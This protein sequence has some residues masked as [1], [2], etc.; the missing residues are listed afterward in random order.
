MPRAGM[1]TRC[2]GPDCASPTHRD[3]L[4][5]AIVGTG[6]IS[7]DEMPG[8]CAGSD[9]CD[10]ADGT[11]ASGAHH[12][13]ATDL[14]LS[15]PTCL[16]CARSGASGETKPTRPLTRKSPPTPLPVM[17]SDAKH[18][19]LPFRPPPLHLQTHGLRFG[20]ALARITESNRACPGDRPR[21][22]HSPKP[23]ARADTLA[24]LRPA[25]LAQMARSQPFR[26]I[27]EFPDEPQDKAPDRQNDDLP[28]HKKQEDHPG[29]L[30]HDAAPCCR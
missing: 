26:G 24:L 22:R 9:P 28:R 3:R 6:F 15:E 14:R 18:R 5:R 20:V 21:R 1:I 27:A 16:R 30:M 29:R 12:A 17:P 8:D 4:L 10:E 11:M 25:A 7:G 13:R 19:Q 2:T 23:D